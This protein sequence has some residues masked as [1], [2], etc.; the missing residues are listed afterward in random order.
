MVAPRRGHESKQR[1]GA[2]GGGVQGL[3]MRGN[4]RVQ[5]VFE[6]PGAEDGDGALGEAALGPPGAAL[7]HA[8]LLERALL[9]EL[10]VDVA[11]AGADGAA[12]GGDG[13]VR[14][15][16]QRAARGAHLRRDRVAQ[17]PELTRDGAQRQRRVRP[18]RPG[19]R[20]RLERRRHRLHLPVVLPVP[21][22]HLHM[23][24]A[25]VHDDDIAMH[26]NSVS[27]PLTTSSF[28]RAC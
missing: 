22:L 12:A 14:V 9:P 3:M 8:E 7:H 25:I 11:E 17:A 13:G 24:A 19:A 16:A 1:K 5:E 28:I 2:T 20:R 10:V 21:L 4:S 6:E 27:Q 18:R 23:H 26:P 15:L